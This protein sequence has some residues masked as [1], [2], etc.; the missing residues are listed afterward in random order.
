MAVDDSFAFTSDAA[1][2][3][4]HLLYTEAWSAESAENGQPSKA[5][6]A[7]DD[8]ALRN[9]SGFSDAIAYYRAEL[10]GGPLLFDDT[11]QDLSRWLTGRGGAAPAEWD[12]VFTP[13]LADYQAGDWPDHDR[14]NK[15]WSAAVIAELEKL[16]PEILED[17]QQAYRRSLPDPPVLVSTVYVGDR[18]PAYTSLHPTHITCSSTHPHSHGLTALEIVLHEASHALVDDLRE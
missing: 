3:L 6:P 14:Q 13:L 9:A 18:L 12:R 10:I 7:P 4:H 11:L 5:Q 15:S 17:L 16:L 1:L 2:N 8:L